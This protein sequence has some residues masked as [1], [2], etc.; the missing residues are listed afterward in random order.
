MLTD[1]S[2]Y[3]VYKLVGEIRIYMNAKGGWTSIPE[4]AKK[5]SSVATMKHCDKNPEYSLTQ[6][7]EKN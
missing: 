5:F 7:V 3:L 4:N 1:R 2:K 6:V